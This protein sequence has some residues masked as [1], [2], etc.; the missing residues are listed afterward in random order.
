MAGIIKDAGLTIEQFC[1]L[2]LNWFRFEEYDHEELI[3]IFRNSLRL[4]I[5]NER[6]YHGLL[7]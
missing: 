2:L 4:H 7:G 5:K 1:E 3:N 6:K